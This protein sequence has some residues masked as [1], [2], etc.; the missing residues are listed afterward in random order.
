MDQDLDDLR[1]VVVAN[2]P[3]MPRARRVSVEPTETGKVLFADPANWERRR[4]VAL[5]HGESGT[6]LGQ[7]SEYVHRSVPGARKLLRETAPISVSATEVVSGSWWL[8]EGRVVEERRPWHERRTAILHLHLSELRVHAPATEVVVHLSYGG[9]ARC[10][11]ALDTM[12]RCEEGEGLLFLP[13]ETNVLEVMSL[14]SKI[15]LR[16]ECG[17]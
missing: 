2:R 16:K 13:A 5:I 3:A 11:L 9:I 6:L 15:S 7:F 1:A 4:G 8:G 12:F 17:L 14:D 10:E